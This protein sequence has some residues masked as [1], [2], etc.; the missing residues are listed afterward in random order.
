LRDPA[1]IAPIMPSAE[2]RSRKVDGS[3]AAVPR[4]MGWPPGLR[5]VNP[6]SKAP[7]GL[8]IIPRGWFGGTASANPHPAVESR[9]SKEP[10]A[11]SSGVSKLNCSKLAVAVVAVPVRIAAELPELR[12]NVWPIPS[13]NN[14]LQPRML[15]APSVPFAR[16]VS[17][18]PL[19]VP[20]LIPI[21][22]GAHKVLLTWY[23]MG[24]HGANLL[25][26]K[27]KLRKS[28][29]FSF[30]DFR[31]KRRLPYA[32]KS[33]EIARWVRPALSAYLA[34]CLFDTAD[35]L[36]SIRLA[37]QNVLSA[38]AALALVL[39]GIS[40]VA[41]CDSWRNDRNAIAPSPPRDGPIPPAMNASRGGP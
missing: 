3:G 7:L 23:V 20:P 39:T 5:D 26:R 11:P 15:L 18:V 17:M 29:D 13:F 24:W 38:V 30:A 36:G 25:C 40:E 35:C 4:V 22:E 16:S 31:T 21:P 37:L 34:P 6:A 28:L 2:A 8:T 19:T 12:V 33:P 14:K 41:D 32:S 9:I 27:A 1:R 10:R